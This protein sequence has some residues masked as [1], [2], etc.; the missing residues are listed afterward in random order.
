[1]L[2]RIDV[3]VK[4]DPGIGVDPDFDR[5]AD[6]HMLELGFFE[7]GG[8][9]HLVGHDREQLLAGRDVGADID[10]AV[11]H[12]ARDRR[13][14]V[15]I[16][17]D[18][19]RLLD[20]RDRGGALRTGR[21]DVLLRGQEV[22]MCAVRLTLRRIRLCGLRL[23]IRARLLDLRRRGGGRI[24]LLERGVAA[25]IVRCAHRLRGG[26]DRAGG[27][28]PLGRELRRRC[29]G[30][31]RHGVELLAPGGVRFERGALDAV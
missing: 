22:G 5:L 14:D 1:M 27:G 18:H 21:L 28:L 2:D 10:L 3:A 15:Q 24:E 6:A 23:R 26:S 13:D 17:V 11:D 30:A 9:P 4:L 29:R 16:A 19:L 20:P 12:L 31:A 25:I 7:I 8:D